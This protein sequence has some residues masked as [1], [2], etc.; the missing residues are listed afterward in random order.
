MVTLLGNEWEFAG[1]WSTVGVL[2]F[3]L[4]LLS[5][6]WFVVRPLYPWLEPTRRSL[7]GRAGFVTL[8]GVSFL[9]WD[10]G[11]GALQGSGVPRAILY[12]ESQ[13]L[14]TPFGF[15]TTVEYIVGPVQGYL[16]LQ[17]VVTFALLAYL[18]A[19]V[20][21]LEWYR[22]RGDV[23]CRVPG[24]VPPANRRVG[25]TL[26]P[27]IPILGVCSGC[28]SPPLLELLLLGV[29][30]TLGTGFTAFRALNW[31]WDGF[32]E[33]ASVTLLVL[34]LRRVTRAVPATAESATGASAVLQRSNEPESSHAG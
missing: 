16:N 20:I 17:L 11:I 1:F 21:H 8:G 30:P 6:F 29:A 4:W 27:W 18:W 7:T 10:V 25:A 9:L 2:V 3:V 5:I 19:A 14:L 32:L 15:F 13:S 26:L 33:V 23:T 31:M 12:A 34:L 28:C 22:A 24:P